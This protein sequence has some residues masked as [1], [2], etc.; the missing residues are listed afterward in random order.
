MSSLMIRAVGPIRVLWQA[1]LQRSRWTQCGVLLLQ[2]SVSWAVM[3][4]Q[5]PISR[6]MV[7]PPLL[8]AILWDGLKAQR[9]IVACQ[10]AI[11]LR[12]DD[13]LLWQDRVWPI[14]TTLATPWGVWLL[15]P[16]A[17]WRRLWLARDSMTL[18]EWRAL[19]RIL[20]HRERMLEH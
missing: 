9:R 17:P 13:C 20:Q 1:A 12:S 6:W 14:T 18:A 19:C 16:A 11:A 8:G 10:G 5:W 7:I 15:L 3:V 4:T 2:G